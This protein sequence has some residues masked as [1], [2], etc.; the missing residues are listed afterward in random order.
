[1]TFEEFVNDQLEKDAV[2]LLD[3]LVEMAMKEG[4]SYS[5]IETEESFMEA[6]KVAFEVYEYLTNLGVD[7]NI[8]MVSS[9]ELEQLELEGS[10]EMTLEDLINDA[11]KNILH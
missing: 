2:G 6:A 11:K 7:G 8:K 3:I 4:D 1:M 9:E 10:Q 5:A